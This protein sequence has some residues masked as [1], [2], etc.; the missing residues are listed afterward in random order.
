MDF[1]KKDEVYF[2]LKKTLGIRSVF[3]KE[4][5]RLIYTT[6]TIE[7]FNRQFKIALVL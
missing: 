5:R 6:N 1:I 2:F 4:V 3:H 7:S